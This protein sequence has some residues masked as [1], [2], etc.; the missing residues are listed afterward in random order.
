[1]SRFLSFL[2]AFFIGQWTVSLQPTDRP[3]VGLTVKALS[4]VLGSDA[5]VLALVL[6]WDGRNSTAISQGSL[7]HCWKLATS[8]ERNPFTPLS[9]KLELSFVRD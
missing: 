1:M 4:E 3:N 8:I 7:I 9:A 6:K 2:E 5:G